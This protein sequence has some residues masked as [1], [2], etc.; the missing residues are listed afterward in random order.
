[1]AWTEQQIEAVWRK[2]RAVPGNDPNVWRIDACGAWMRRSSHGDRGSQYGWEID[3][4]R[5]NGGDHISNL[6]PLQWQNNA[7]KSDDRLVCVVTASG[8]KNVAKR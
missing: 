3:H 5:P 8:A 6:Q 1:M 7:A 2:G 4:I